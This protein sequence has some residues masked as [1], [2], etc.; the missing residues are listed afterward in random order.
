[1][2]HLLDANTFMESARTYYPMDMAPGFWAWLR[3]THERGYLASV[4]AVYDEIMDGKKD[5]ELVK[6][7]KDMPPSFWLADTSESLTTITK[8]GG[9][10][11]DKERSYSEAAKAEF[12]ASADLRLIAQASATGGVVVTRETS[13]PDAKKRVKIPD[14]CRAFD[15]PC[16]QPFPVYQSLGL[17]L[18]VSDA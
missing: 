14:V 13:A 11:N 10:A 4:R 16:L 2:I 18:S 6:W 1:M 9:W 12:M 17:K 3:S 5:D 15:I 7:A 8:L